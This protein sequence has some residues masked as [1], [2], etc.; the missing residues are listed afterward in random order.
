MNHAVLQVLCAA[1]GTLGFSVFFR[2]RASHLPIATLGGALSWAVYLLVQAV[3]GSVFFSTLVSALVVCLWAE[4]M[5]RLRKAPAT[6]FLV[7]GIIPL[8]PGGALYHTMR[9]VVSGDMETFLA[10][11]TETVFVAVGIAGGILIA[12]EIVRVV[13]RLLSKKRRRPSA[14][15]DPE[16]Q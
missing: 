16:G 14:A 11:G 3:G 1:L 5:A 2:V 13:V 6:V 9:G 8:L 10:R 7:P 15:G 4:T 12:S